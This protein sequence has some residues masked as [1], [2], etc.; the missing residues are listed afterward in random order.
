MRALAG[1]PIF[2]RLAEPFGGTS[3]I[4][5]EHAAPVHNGRVEERKLTSWD[6]S[7]H[8][9]GGRFRKLQR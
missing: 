8:S 1:L 9:V 6:W 3:E 7:S 4:M 5:K 2:S